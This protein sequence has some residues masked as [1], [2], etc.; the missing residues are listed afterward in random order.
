[1][2]STFNYIT[3]V[4]D[5]SSLTQTYNWTVPNGITTSKALIY[6]YG[7]NSSST[8]RDTSNAVF[9]IIPSNDITVTSPNGGE[10]WVGLSGHTITWTNLPTASGQYNVQYSLNGGNSWTTVATNI[11]GNSYNWTL[12]NTSSTTCW[13]RVTD[14]VNNCK[15]DDNN[16]AFTITPATPFL[17]SPN[18]GEVLYSG[19]VQNITWTTSKLYT[20]ARLEYSTDNGTTW[21]LITNAA[22]NNGSYAWT[23]PNQNSTTCLVRISNTGD[24][25]VSDVSNAV[26]TIKPAV[27][28]LT[29]NGGDVITVGG[30]TVT[31]ITFDRSPAWSTYAIEYTLDDGATWTNIT[32]SFSATTNPATYNWNV[33]NIFSDKARVR[34]KP[35]AN[36]YVDMSDNVFSIIKAVTLIQ[37]NFGG[38]MQVGTTY[39]ISWSS[40]GISSLYDIFYSTN[41]GSTFTNI[42]TGYSTSNNKYTWTVPNI[43]STNC[44]ILIRDNVNSCKTDTSDLPFTISTTAAPIMLVTPNGNAD[45]IY[46]CSNYTINWNET[47]TIGTYTIAYSTNAGSSWTNIVSNYSTTTHSYVWAVPNTIASTTVLLR[48]SSA[49]NS[50]VYDLSDAYFSIIPPTYT[51]V[52]TGNW[53]VPSNWANNLIPPSPLTAACAEI[54]IDPVANGECVLNKTQEMKPGTKI[55]VKA[56]KKFRIPGNLE[57]Q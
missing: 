19:T 49:G 27:T 22:S 25:S 55:T 15:Y 53:D 47:S 4:S 3:A 43:V 42:V 40:D 41:G 23:I 13:V 10:S 5:N 38:I 30:C 17:L 37:P 44:R 16:A 11:T 8:I 32:S 28:I 45:T 12:P 35:T 34:V 9:N 50:A 48:V 2:G 21:T 18:G 33:P 14:Y 31:S 1:S 51:F 46:A 26:F 24:M 36:S 7:S 57:I 54:I 52:G 29:P 20:T 39:D 56:G 6:V